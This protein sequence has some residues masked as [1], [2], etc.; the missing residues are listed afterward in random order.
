MLFIVNVTLKKRDNNDKKSMSR[1]YTH[2]VD[3]DDEEGARVKVFEYYNGK[4][5]YQVGDKDRTGTPILKHE[6]VI[7]NIGT[8]I[9]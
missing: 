7:E 2:L 6:I 5:T 4:N 3:A 8:T 9:I 1:N